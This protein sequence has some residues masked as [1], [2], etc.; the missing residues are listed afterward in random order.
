MFKETQIIKKHYKSNTGIVKDK[1]SQ[2]GWREHNTIQTPCGKAS[3]N[4]L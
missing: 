2:V 4:F 3:G 1:I